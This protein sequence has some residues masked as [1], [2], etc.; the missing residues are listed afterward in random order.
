MPE[1]DKIRAVLGLL[2]LASVL[3]GALMV[4]ARG[5]YVVVLLL[6]GL[7]PQSASSPAPIIGVFAAGTAVTFGLLWWA[8]SR[9][10]RKD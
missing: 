7:V 2:V 6:C 9:L 1:L 8:L 4:A 10:T 5:V 3:C